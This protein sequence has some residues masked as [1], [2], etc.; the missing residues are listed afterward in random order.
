MLGDR[1]GAKLKQAPYE[2]YFQEKCNIAAG[3]YSDDCAT[4]GSTIT[5]YGVL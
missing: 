3:D 1:C 4:D 2:A 5:S